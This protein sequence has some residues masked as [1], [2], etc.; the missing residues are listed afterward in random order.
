VLM[1]HLIAV[2]RSL[3]PLASVVSPDFSVSIVPRR[4][5]SLVVRLLGWD[6]I[7]P[8]RSRCHLIGNALVHRREI[9]QAPALVVTP[10]MGCSL[11]ELLCALAISGRASAGDRLGHA[12]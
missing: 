8:A 6:R 2:K 4:V 9:E 12:H 10:F 11:G 7:V 1:P 3:V 5:R